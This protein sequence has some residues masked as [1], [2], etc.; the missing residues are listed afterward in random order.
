MKRLLII[1]FP[2]VVCTFIFIYS[3][4]SEKSIVRQVSKHLDPDKPTIIIDAGHGGFDGGTSAA[5]GTIEKDINLNI[6]LYLRDY[7]EFL[8]YKTVLTREGDISLED[9]GL[10]TIRTRK[11]SDIHN[12]MK[13]MEKT[14]NA[15]FVSIHQN[16]FSVEKY[17]GLQV[18][19][20]PNFSEKSSLLATDIQEN[21]VE[22][23]QPDNDRQITECGT[24]VFLIYNAV[25]PAVLVE[26]GFL[27]NEEEA[28]LLKTEE[29]QK[30]I[31]F[32][33][34][35]GIQD[36]VRNEKYG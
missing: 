16:H 25:K 28:S 29:Y 1:I 31:A 9:E 33:I 11:T 35:L 7:L 4:A 34:A 14:D 27:S 30:R 19:Y 12:R 26:C 15:I 5:G 18:F 22:L 32:A 36:Y 21:V 23:L 13:L 17:K 24:S 3:C 10:S 6:S 2:L 20:S 8:G